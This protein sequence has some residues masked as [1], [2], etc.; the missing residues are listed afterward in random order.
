MRNTLIC[1]V[2]TSLLN[3]LKYAEESIKQV[4]DD[5]NWNQ[6]ALLLLQRKNSDRICGAE[7]NSITS[8][9]EKKLLAARIRLIFLVSDTDD[10][11]NTGNILKLYYDNK[12]NNSLF[13]EKVEVRVL[14][15]LRDDDVKA[16]KQQGLKNLVKEISTEVRKFT[17]EAIAINATGGY[18]AQISFAGMIGQALEMPV[19]YLF[20]KFSEVIELPPQPVALDLAFW[21]NNY[22]LFAQLEDEP[23]IEELQLE[24]NLESEYLYSLIDKETLGETNV[25]S[26]SAMGVL[27]NE[28]CRLQFAKQETTILSLVPKD[29]TEPSRKAINL[30][31]DHGKDI[32]QEFSE[33]ICYSPY[34]KKIINSLPF[35]PKRTNPIRRTTDKGIVEFVLTWTSAGLGICIETTG[36]NLAETNT[37]ALHLQKEFAENN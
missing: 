18:K 23:T 27:F 11:K 17:P 22:L 30:R 4:F 1:T 34:V 13:F 16:F 35:N 3:N 9:C 28:R 33:R 14:E 20:E 25:V 7:I 6:L 29:E 21:L 12:K 19:Y 10:G 15:G 32:L 36:R 5:R 26:L 37:I 2:G 24:A 31:D 8:I